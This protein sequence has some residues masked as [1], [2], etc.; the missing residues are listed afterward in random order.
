M[1][2]RAVTCCNE[3]VTHINAGTYTIGAITAVRGYVPLYADSDLATLKVHVETPLRQLLIANRGVMQ[4]IV[5][6][7]IHVQMRVNPFDNDAVD[8]L[9][10]LCQEIS[11][12]IA[13]TTLPSGFQWVG[14]DEPELDDELP[15]NRR[16]QGLITPRFVQF[17]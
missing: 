5:Q 14:E 6:P 3:L 13:K 7:R 9:T 11:D 4:H 2:A 12:R 17:A 10:E 15:T 1:T 8:A 16:F